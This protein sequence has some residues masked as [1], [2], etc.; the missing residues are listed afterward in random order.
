MLPLIGQLTQVQF[1][2]TWPLWGIPIAAAVLL[3]LLTREFVNLPLLP[4]ERRK[5]RRQ[6]IFAFIT[7][8][9]IIA[10]LLAALSHPY[11]EATQETQGNPRVTVLIDQSGSMQYLDTKFADGLTEILKRRIPTT[12]K[13]IGANLTSDIGGATLRNLEPGGNILLISDG[14]VNT[15]P[16]LEDVSFYA[17]TL[18]ATVSAINLSASQD[19]AAVVVDGPAKV[20][21][22]SDA[23]FAVTVTATDESRLRHLA[24]LVD[25]SQVIDRDVTP[26]TYSFT[27]QFPKGNHRIEARITTPDANP[28]NDVFYKEVRVLEKPKILLLTQ[29]SSPL[30]LL[31]RQ[32]YDIDKRSSLPR[33][34]SPYYAI[35]ADDVPVEALRDT[36]ALHNYLID[37][38]GQYYGN[39][40]V[41]FGGMNSFDRG[42]YAGSSL[43]PLLPVRVGKGERKKGGA[44]LVF[45]MDVSG[46]TSKTKYRFAG[47]QLVQYNESVPTLDVIK[48]QLVN[49]IQQ[50]QI[51]NKAAVIIFGVPP[52]T[53]SDTVEA[54]ITES[55]RVVDKLDFL[56][57]NR[58][59]ILDRVPR[60]VGGGPG[61]PDI[62]FRGAVELLKSVQG[63][64][65]IILLSDGRY[66]PGIGADSPAKQELLTLA[67]N[68]HKL[69]GVN[70]MA[71]GVGATDPAEFA[72][73]VD[74]QFLKELAVAGDGTYDRATQLNSLLVK[75]GDPKAKE[76]GQE[77]IL[78][79][80]SLTHFITRGIEPTAILNAY[81]QVVPKDTAELLITADSGQPAL[82]VWR[83]GNG[84]VATWTVFAGNNLGQLLNGN[85]SL[86]I[87]RTV[88]WAIGD[89]QRKEPYFID[90]PDT[91]INDKGYIR[92][93]SDS[94]V[95]AEEL[96]FTKD[97]STY[98]AQ[99]QPSQ[100]GFSSLLNQEYAVD[101]PS[102]YDA[103]GMNPGLGR[104][105]SSTGGKVFKPSESDAIIEYIKAVS[106]RV[107]LV[108][109]SMAT[110]FIVAAMLLLLLEIG[111]RRITERRRD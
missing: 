3:L 102:E 15:G 27:R 60:I 59:E 17:T 107:T 67:A 19:D 93:R 31:L 33:D 79:P 35:V 71:I 4:E 76:F 89:P 39:G 40:I 57:N 5:Q 72:T 20:V 52:G 111:V 55:V 63:D 66:S 44:N 100:V 43:E 48:A 13:V 51:D 69:Y 94:P 78:V 98:T 2:Q 32:L 85:N 6:R 90:I 28:D 108:K 96:V 99:F 14:N 47:G 64:K 22:D 16:T 83:Y 86:L 77:F 103:V 97:G 53:T 12:V 10:L 18:N 11:I 87:S 70:F 23:Q 106:R 7:R 95:V 49:A 54:R 46:S 41:L 1:Q 73:K 88:N 110:P 34:L 25:G 26:G 65:N 9:L 62:A 61:A 38:Q 36:Q 30:E 21:A 91:R 68:A 8:L 56:Y 42:D 81:N 58:K 74:E 29:R 75:W 92:V 24:V 82:T 101:R 50:L 105:V 109:R 84:R 45:V 104:V 37:E 80:L